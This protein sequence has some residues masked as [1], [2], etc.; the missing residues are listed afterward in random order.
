M[1]KIDGSRQR[2]P[3]AGKFINAISPGYMDTVLNRVPALD[4]QKK[5]WV[6]LTPAL[7]FLSVSASA[8]HLTVTKSGRAFPCLHDRPKV[9]TGGGYT[10]W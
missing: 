8:R 3:R 2:P 6:N 9:S 7:A 1:M 10:C 4:A 5:I